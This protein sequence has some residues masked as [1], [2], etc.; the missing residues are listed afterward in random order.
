MKTKGPYIPRAQYTTLRR[1]IMALLEEDELSARDISAALRIP[2]KEVIFHL[3]HIRSAC[4]HNIHHLRLIPAL[5]RKC[6]FVFNKR[7]RLAKPGKCPVC[8][9]E[10]I[11][12]PLYTLR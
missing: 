7:E 6:G 4:R 8:R 11:A 9:N 10:Q 2:E 1:A 3:E 5:C 12:E